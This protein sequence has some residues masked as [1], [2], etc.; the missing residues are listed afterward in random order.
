MYSSDKNDGDVFIDGFKLG[1]DDNEIRKH[2]GVV[3]QDSVLDD[4]LTVKENLMTR[5][6]FYELTK[7]EL[8][9]KVDE[10]NKICELGEFINRPYGKLSGGQRRRADI[11]RALI[12]TPKYCSWMN[13]QRDLTQ[14]QKTAYG[15]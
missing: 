3:F 9:N 14:R 10:V 1:N 5:G 8:N 13:L 15:I 12:N 11:A 4:L 6:K 2:I 7:E